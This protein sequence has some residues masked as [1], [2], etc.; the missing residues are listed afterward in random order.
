MERSVTNS[1]IRNGMK[2]RH[3]SFPNFEFESLINNDDVLIR[4]KSEQNIHNVKKKLLHKILIS[5]SLEFSERDTKINN[6]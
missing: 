1:K 5:Y 4:V 3:L 2:N 6:K